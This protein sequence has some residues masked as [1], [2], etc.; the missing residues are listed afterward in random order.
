MGRFGSMK[1]FTLLCI[2]L[3]EI[4]IMKNT[5]I[6]SKR[7]SELVCTDDGY[8]C[9]STYL[10]ELNG[11]IDEITI[12]TDNFVCKSHFTKWTDD[13]FNLIV[14]NVVPKFKRYTTNNKK[15]Y[16]SLVD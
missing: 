1:Y 11:K 15:F 14:K 12:N 16:D 8:Y 13:E 2:T 5:Q 3:K 7:V 10:V 6:K 9:L 4:N